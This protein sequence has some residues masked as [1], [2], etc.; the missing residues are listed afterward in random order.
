MKFISLLTLLFCL[1]A[2]VL[3]SQ[4]SKYRFGVQI[5]TGISDLVFHNPQYPSFETLNREGTTWRLSPGIAAL[6]R[7]EVNERL[8][9]QAGL[10]YELSGYRVK[11]FVLYQSTPEMP[12]PVRLG[13][14]KG[15][16]H[17]PDF[18]LSFYFKVTPFRGAGR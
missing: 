12:E 10:G 6:C 1:Q 14:A 17:Y 2:P 8:W 15:T 11:E 13:T 5:Q 7:Y 4:S 16:I 18:N 9:F 3:H